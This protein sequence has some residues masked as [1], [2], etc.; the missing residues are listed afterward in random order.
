MQN[1]TDTTP[2][3][4]FEVLDNVFMMDPN[5]IG[6]KTPWQLIEVLQDGTKIWKPLKIKRSAN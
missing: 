3:K 2:V 4:P 6:T 5:N 1:Y